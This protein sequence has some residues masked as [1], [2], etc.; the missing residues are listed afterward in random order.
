MQSK[1]DIVSRQT[2][3]DAAVSPLVMMTSLLPRTAGVVLAALSAFIV[4]SAAVV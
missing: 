2:A 1:S 3:A 4:S